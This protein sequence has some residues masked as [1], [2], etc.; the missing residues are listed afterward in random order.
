MN[1]INIIAEIGANHNGDISLA[2]EMINAAHE[3]GADYAKF[4]SWKEDNLRKGPWDEDDSP[5]FGFKNK[6]DFYKH[7]QLTDEQHH[8]L[9]EHCNKVGIKFLTTC[10]D[11]PRASF[12]STLG[13]DTIKVA[14]CDS[15]N[16]DM[17]VDLAGRFNRVICSTGMTT[18]AEARDLM[19]WLAFYCKKHVVLHCVSMYPTPLD[20]VSIEKMFWIKDT[21]NPVGYRDADG[22][23][24]WGVSDHS[25]GTTVPKV[26]ICYGATWIEKHFTTDKKLIGPDNYMSIEPSELKD[27]RNFAND[28]I[29]IQKCDSSDVYEEEMALREVIKDRFSGAV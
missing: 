17:I 16:H 13:M 27:I 26:A 15:T 23:G 9:I 11:Q 28:F 7:A 18:Q 8:E 19:K 1:K 29:E 3:N 4:Q 2:K 21:L 6:R 22:P 10:F 14:S 25:L 5:F 12:L 20:K 24:E